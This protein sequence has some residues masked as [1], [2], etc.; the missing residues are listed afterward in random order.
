MGNFRKNHVQSSITLPECMTLPENLPTTIFSVKLM[1]LCICIGVTHWRLSNLAGLFENCFMNLW[2]IIN[3]PTYT[4]L[5]FRL[6]WTTY[7][8]IHL[9][10]PI[11]QAH[12]W[13]SVET[14]RF[15]LWC[16]GSVKTK[17]GKGLADADC[18]SLVRQP[19]RPNLTFD[20]SQLRK[21]HYGIEGS[22]ADNSADHPQKS[23]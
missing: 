7:F 13:S 11:L 12:F 9:C 14:S 10:Y 22:R 15:L 3:A 16:Q 18:R 2:W 6:K 20:R 23:Q 17:G 1:H 19:R 8:W 5:I 4:P 21:W